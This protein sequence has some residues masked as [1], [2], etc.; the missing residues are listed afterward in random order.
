M[1]RIIMTTVVA[2]L[3]ATSAQ[4]RDYNVDS[5]HSNVGFKVKHMMVSNV[6]GHFS[7]FS[8]TMSWDPSAPQ[9]AKVN[10]TVQVTSLDT[11][12]DKRDDHLRSADF[13]DVQAHP[14]A[15]FV[16]TKLEPQGGDKF[17]LYG[18]LTLRGVTR[19][20]VLDLALV[21]A[22]PDGSRVGWEATAT[23]NRQDFGVSWSK[24]LD[25][26]GVAVSDEVTLELEIQGV[27][28]K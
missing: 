12:N 26:G 5:V 10:V 11:D 8:G 17:K 23:F 19:P 25:N 28:P 1:Q 27:L 2:L 15:T 9:D 16:S 13:F 18:D 3:A 24:V 7:D 21:G 6:R 14:T 20:L 22:A 4:A